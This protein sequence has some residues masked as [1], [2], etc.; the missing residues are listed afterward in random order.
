MNDKPRRF[1][2]IH[3][4]TLLLATAAFG[5]VLLIQF[6][7]RGGSV[8]SDWLTVNGLSSRITVQQTY[9]QYLSKQVVTCEL[10]NDR[11]GPLAVPEP[12]NV[13]CDIVLNAA[14]GRSVVLESYV[15]VTPG[16]PTADW[17]RVLSPGEM[18]RYA[19]PVEMLQRG[20]WVSFRTPRAEYAL[21]PAAE[22]EIR[23][24]YEWNGQQLN[25]SIPTSNSFDPSIVWVGK[26]TSH[27]VQ[28]RFDVWTPARVLRIIC[29][30]LL[31]VPMT[32]LACE[33]LI[34]RRSKP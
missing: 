4:I 20:D 9:I 3:L 26:C 34:R 31:A 24:R 14:D 5:I 11:D 13:Y 33:C 23:H 16:I 28:L 7:P 1:W 22:I 32:I 29:Q 6:W 10:R 21:N 25:A 15:T 27:G 12:G 2:Q 17:F 18:L 8:C 30:L 19:Y